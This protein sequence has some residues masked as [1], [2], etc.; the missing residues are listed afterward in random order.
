MLKT[1]VSHVTIYTLLTVCFIEVENISLTRVSI[2]FMQVYGV[3]VYEGF[4][5]SE[6]A[7]TQRQDRFD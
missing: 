1:H 7:Y 5:S 3:A 2:Q 4:L 6:A